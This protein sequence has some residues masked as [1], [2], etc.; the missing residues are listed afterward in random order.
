MAHRDIP[1]QHLAAGLSQCLPIM[2]EAVV[3][4]SDDKS[5]NFNK[6]KGRL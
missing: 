4:R 6:R 5:V 1:I 2:A 3:V